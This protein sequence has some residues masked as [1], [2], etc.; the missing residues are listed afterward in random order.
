MDRTGKLKI[1]EALPDEKYRQ[2]ESM[3]RW[4]TYQRNTEIVSYGEKGTDV[5]FVGKGHVRTTMFSV[6]GKEIAF[7]DLFDGEIFGE[8]SALDGLPRSA[9]VVAIDPSDIGIMSSRDFAEVR[10]RYPEVSDALMRRLVGI[11]RR[12]TD[13]V[14]VYDALSVRDRVRKEILHLAQQ[15]M[16][17]PNTAVIPYMPKHAE[18]ANRID[19]HREAVT[20]E[21]NVLSQKGLI[22]R[23][24]RELTVTDVAGL[25]ELVPEI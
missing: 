13:R 22:R 8:L 12:L 21:L 7:Q 24:N 6:L 15:H 11:I 20:R 9:S 17:G 10:G 2:V 1:F 5:F 4:R 25:A 14:Y 16:T 3:I 18:I 23:S 19:T